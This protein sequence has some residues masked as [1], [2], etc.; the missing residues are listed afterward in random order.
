MSYDFQGTFT[1]IISFDY[2]VRESKKLKT[3]LKIGI[4][5]CD[6]QVKGGREII[7]S[8]IPVFIIDLPF[9]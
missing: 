8:A 7:S 6:L 9:P 4:L 1:Y 5:A 2:Y 3:L